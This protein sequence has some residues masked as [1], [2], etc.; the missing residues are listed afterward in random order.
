MKRFKDKVA[1]I[2]GAASGIGRSLAF[3]AVLEGMKVVLADVDEQSL[4]K[5]GRELQAI[6]GNILTIRTDVSKSPEVEALAQK[7]LEVFGGVDLLCNNA[8]V[9]SGNTIWESSLSDWEWV[10]SVNLWGVIHGIHV[11]TPIMIA[12]NR[13]CHI[14]N[15]ASIAGLVSPP[16][17]GIYN[18]TKYGVVALSECL[19]QE[20]IQCKAKINVSVLCPAYVRTRI[21]SSERNRPVGNKAIQHIATPAEEEAVWQSL[22]AAKY[23]ILSPDQIADQVFEAIRAERFYILTH[24][25]S[26]TWVKSRM[27][28]ILEGKNPPLFSV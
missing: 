9:A 15:T 17:Q 25:E 26:K 4:N 18:V 2:T 19:Y 27:E 7:T 24:P 22:E 16:H 5:T 20:L 28:S 10:L 8:G 3:R 12:Q 1:V 23:S 13:K 14:V 6:G 21:M 11:F